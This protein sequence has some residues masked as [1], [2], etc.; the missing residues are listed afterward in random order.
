VALVGVVAIGSTIWVLAGDSS[1]DDRDTRDTMQV[2]DPDL[3]ITASIPRSW[4]YARAGVPGGGFSAANGPV[5]W[6]V[7]S[8]C[9]RADRTHVDLS[10]SSIEYP[11][12]VPIPRPA[13]SFTEK[14]GTGLTHDPMLPCGAAVQRIDFSVGRTQWTGIL[15][16]GPDATATERQH[17]YDV[18]STMGVD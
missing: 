12:Q 1:P 18:L 13:R 9:T 7:D 3:R 15:R 5:T 16:F 11:N 4:Q 2:H 17:A 10:I 8:P 6:S 14:D